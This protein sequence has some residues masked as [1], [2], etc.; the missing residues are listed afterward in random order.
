[1][2]V[3]PDDF[4]CRHCGLPVRYGVTGKFSFSLDAEQVPGGGYRLEDTD[5]GE[6]IATYV[7]VAD[8]EPGALGFRKHDCPAKKSGWLGP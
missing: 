3:G 4:Q 1:M 5:T 7:R 2:S 8:R 6:W